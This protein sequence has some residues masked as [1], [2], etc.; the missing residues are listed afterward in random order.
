MNHRPT[1]EIH[2]TPELELLATEHEASG[3]KV[4]TLPARIGDRT[5][6]FDGVRSV[7]PLD[8]PVRDN[9]SLDELE[10]SLWEGLYRL[11]ADRVVI[12]WPDA[13][14]MARLSDPEFNEALDVLMQVAYGLSLER[15]TLG[16]PK[17][18]KVVL[19]T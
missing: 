6:F 16:K 7:L 15:P 8:P 13:L 14:H 5:D 4:Y 3:W 17:R 2:S 1:F 12:V 10:D 18:M 11:A 19:G 9:V